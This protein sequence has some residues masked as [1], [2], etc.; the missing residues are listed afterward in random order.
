MKNI[1]LVSHGLLAE[2]VKSSLEM[3]AGKQP[4]LHT[5]SLTPDGDNLQ[6]GEELERK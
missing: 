4:N 3:I 6:F 2:G 1:V 5:I